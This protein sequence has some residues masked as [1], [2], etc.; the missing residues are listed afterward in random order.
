MA[1]ARG[2][3]VRS[4]ERGSGDPSVRAIEVD[5]GPAGTFDA[6]MA[7]VFPSAPDRLC[8][9]VH[10]T[11][12]PGS[13]GWG[14]LAATERGAAAR[15][16]MIERAVADARAYVAGGVRTVVV[17]NFHDAPFDRAGV[18][19]AT[20]AAMALA[21]DAVTAVDGILCVGVNVLRNDA[22]TALGIAAA[23]GARFVRVNVHTGAM[24]TDQGVI[25][26]RAAETLRERARLGLDDVR[27][28]AD[29]HVKHATPFAGERL[30]DAA[31]DAELRGRAG[32]LV[33]SGA[34]TGSAPDVARVET[35]RGAVGGSIPILL[36]SGLGVDNA[37]R[38]MG[39]ADGAFVGTSVKFGGDVREAVDPERVAALL[40]ACG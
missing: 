4:G 20:V 22:A 13:A 28:Y 23:T 5:T 7:D 25:E 21:V 10:L 11:P 2:R 24:V 40:Q 12:T 19:P 39:A 27:I 35:V 14:V 31:R 15:A 38:L 16:L 33:V 17:E 8:G 26:G 37:S 1:T 9:V 30:E 18:A 34:A 29:V 6:L 32:G 36:G 3:R